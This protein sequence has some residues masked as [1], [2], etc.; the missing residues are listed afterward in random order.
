[1]TPTA[2]TTDRASRPRVAG[3]RE[4][5]VLDAVVDLLVEVGYDRLTF[6][7]VASAA[8]VS[9]A[10]L[11][12]RWTGK[13]DLVL[14]AVEQLFD[15][16]EDGHAEAA[17]TGTFVG[18]L[19]AMFCQSTEMLEQLPAILAG[20]LPALQRDPELSAEFTERIIKPKTARLHAVLLRA[21]QR[22]EIREDADLATLAAVLPAMNF[23]RV[24]TTGECPDD[25]YV[26]TVI[27]EVLLP[28]CRA[29]LADDSS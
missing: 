17:N 25:A 20:S 14:S 4:R 26:R 23:H 10:T 8:K 21:Q 24:M 11:Y 13:A 27:H 28:A 2:A 22:G 5:E 1:M 15:R 29:G 18:D 3:D 16:A 9:K 7:A 6:D 19:E 12:R